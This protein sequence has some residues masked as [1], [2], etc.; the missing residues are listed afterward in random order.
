MRISDWSS[1]VCSS[2]LSSTASSYR[3]T[4][5]R[6][7]GRYELA[8]EDVEAFAR[9]REQPAPVSV[10]PGRR[11]WGRSDARRGGEECVS[12]CRSRGPVYHLKKTTSQIMIPTV[13]REI[14]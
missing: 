12:T 7:R 8:V 14:S 4:A 10:R 1:D 5:V 13:D 11:E 6:V 9:E 3:L 2:D